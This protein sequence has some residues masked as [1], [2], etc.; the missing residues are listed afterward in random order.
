MYLINRVFESFFEFND[1]SEDINESDKTDISVDDVLKFME[2]LIKKQRELAD[3]GKTVRNTF[4]K[5][6]DD[7]DKGLEAYFDTLRKVKN[8]DEDEYIKYLSS[9]GYGTFK[10]MSARFAAYA[11]EGV[12]EEEKIKLAK[13]IQGQARKKG[14]KNSRDLMKLIKDKE[15]IGKRPFIGMMSEL[16]R[17]EPKRIKT[18]PRIM[19]L[20]DDNDESRLFNDNMYEFDDESFS[21]GLKEDLLVKIKYF[22]NL[23][24]LG[25]LEL[26][27]IDIISSASR[28][29]NTGD[30]PLSWGELSYQRALTLSTVILEVA[31]LFEMSDADIEKIR[32]KIFLD[33]YGSNGDGTSGPNPPEGIKFGYYDNKGEFIRGDKRN[34]VVIYSL[35]KEG[36]PEKEDVVIEMD[37]LDDSKEYNEF[38]YVN[39][40][41][42]GDMLNI[43]KNE[44]PSSI[45]D[46]DSK[47]QIMGVIPY[48]NGVPMREPKTTTPKKRTEKRE[49]FVKVGCPKPRD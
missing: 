24:I 4:G 19:E 23:I 44:D 36:K 42:K 49:R 28:Y 7:P 32:K 27:S 47:Y 26:E 20:I 31:K 17:M 39:I 2:A 11:W 43:G 3:E 6:Q 15:I 35:D 40:I 25:E 14:Y 8:M 5:N 45:T 37:P 16:I 29:R 38:R 10:G 46:E 9:E 34:E 21:E 30:E 13:N 48:I 41:I 33:F 22:I 12:T 18:T 1:K